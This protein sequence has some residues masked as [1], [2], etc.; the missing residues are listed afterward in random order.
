MLQKLLELL[1]SH[2]GQLT[3]EQICAE[4]GVTP[5]GLQAMLDILIRKGRVTADLLDGENIC[6]TPC[7]SCPFLG[8]CS[9]ER[10]NQETIYRLV[11]RT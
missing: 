4:L 5:S 3:Q 7:E 10:D 9:K 8:N 2:P 6:S 11:S 1:E